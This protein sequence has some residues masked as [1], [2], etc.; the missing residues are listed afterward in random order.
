MLSK[1]HQINKYQKNICGQRKLK[2]S[3]TKLGTRLTGGREEFS[4]PAMLS[5]CFYADLQWS[6]HL[7]QF[8]TFHA[9]VPL[10]KAA[11]SRN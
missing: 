8:W 9:A 1:K 4:T 6:E 2:V 7:S 5:F 11:S 3:S 10:V